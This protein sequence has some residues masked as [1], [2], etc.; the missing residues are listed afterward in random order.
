MT[1]RAKGGRLDYEAPM[2]ALTDE[3]R[4]KIAQ[5][6]PEILEFLQAGDKVTAADEPPIR[7][8][9]R[10][11]NLPL[12]FAQERLWFIDQLQPGSTGY[13]I[14]RALRILG[15]LQVEVLER[16]INEI[17]RR[18]EVLRTTF[19]TT[20]QGQPVQV[21]HEHEWRSVPMVDLEALSERERMEQARQLIEEERLRPF[22]LSRGPLMRVRLLQLG[23]TDQVISYT[24]HH[25][26]SDGWS[27]GVLNRELGVLYEAFANGQPS[28]LPELPIQYA[29]FAVW[30]REWLQ[31]E[32]L[33]KQL[34]Y[35]K[36]QLVGVIPLQLPTDYSRPVIQTFNGA[37][38]E[39]R[40][41]SETA[42]GLK[43]LCRDN[44]VTL[45]MTLLAGFQVLLSR[46]SGQEDIAVASPIANRHGTE[47]ENLIGFFVNM[48][49][50]RTDLSG[51]PTVL[52]LL[53]R[54][55]EVTLGAYSHQDLPFEKLVEELRPERDM[56]RNPLVQV[57]FALQNA[58]DEGLELRGIKLQLIGGAQEVTRLDLEAHFWESKQGITGRLIYNMDLFESG[59]IG[60]MAGHLERLLEEMV[61]KPEGRISELEL[62]G[63][64]EREQILVGWNQ[65]RREYPKKKCI[66]ELFEE[67]AK[68]S[69]EAVA[70]VFENKHLTYEELNR[71][72]NQLAHFLRGLG[73]KP[74]VPVGICVER[75]LDLI[76][77]LLGIWKAG[78]AY[79]PLD[80]AY[81]KERIT[82]ILENASIQILISQGP[83]AP[84][85]SRPGIQTVA[86]DEDWPLIVEGPIE[87]PDNGISVENLAYII[88]TSGFTGQPKGVMIEHR[89]LGHNAEAMSVPLSIDRNTRY[90]HTAS[91]GFFS[92]MRQFVLPLTRGGTLV[93]ASSEQI[94]DP[95]SLFRLIKGNHVTVIDLVPSYWRNCIFALTGLELESRTSLLDND[96]KLILSSGEALLSDLP[97]KWTCELKHGAQLVNMF[98]RA[99][100]TGIVSLFPI[101]MENGSAVRTVQ[102]GRPIANT[103]IYLLDKNLNPVPIGVAGELYI[104]GR[105]LAR[106]YSG[107]A[108]LTAE[109]F[110]GNPFSNEP[111]SRLYRTGDLCR[112]QPGGVM[113]FVGRIDAAR[114]K[115]FELEKEKRAIVISSTFTADPV[116]EPLKFWMSEL[117]ILAE[118]RL[119]PYNQVF[120]QLLDPAGLQARN[121]LGVS[122]VLIRIEDF[123]RHKLVETEEIRGQVLDFVA[124]V[125]AAADHSVCPYIVGLCP[126]S[127]DGQLGS[128][129]REM[130]DLVAAELN[131]SK[132]VRLIKSDEWKQAYPV[133]EY[134]D[135]YS[136]ELGHIPYTPE[137]YTAMGTVLARK[138]FAL[139]TLPYK[140]IAVD[141]DH[142]L[143]TGICAE[144]G[145]LGITIDPARQALQRF[146]LD[147]KEA[148]RLLCLCSKN[149]ESDVAEVFRTRS[150]MCLSR[151]DFVAWRINWKAKSENLK[152]LAEELGVGLDSFI[153]IDDNPLECAEVE[154]NCPQ[155]L[156][157]QL[158]QKSE[159]ISEFLEHLWVFDLLET[160]ETDKRRTQLY[161][162]NSERERFR[163]ESQSLEAFLAGLKLRLQITDVKF[164]QLPRV[165]QLTQRTNQFNTTAIRR[166]EIELERLLKGKEL[167][168]MVVEVQDRFGDYG[169][170]GAMLFKEEIEAISVDTFLLSCRV[171]GKG[172]EHRML[173][174]LGTIACQRGLEFVEVHYRATGKNQLA[175]DF[176][177]SAG[178]QS[179]EHQ[180]DGGVFRLTARS[181]KDLVYVPG[182]SKVGPPG[183]RANGLRTTAQRTSSGTWMRIALELSQVEQIRQ[184]LDARKQKTGVQRSR[185]YIAP[186]TPTEEILAGIWSSMLGVES[187][188]ITDDFFSLGGHSFLA[189]QFLSR[190]RSVFKVELPLK[191]LFEVPT[192][193]GLSERVEA[194]RRSGAGL[195]TPEIRRVGRDRSWPLSYAQEQLWQYC[196]WAL[197]QSDSVGLHV[198]IVLPIGGPLQ[199][200][201]LERAINEMV[202]RHEV[203]RT[204]YKNSEAGPVQVIHD[205]QYREL[206][207]ADLEGLK[208]QPREEELK[209]LITEDAQRLFDLERGPVLRTTLVRLG[210]D[211]HTILH[212]VHHIATDFFSQ[213]IW[214]RETR[215]LYDAFS[216]S[217]ESPLAE[218][219][220]QYADY[221]VW[222]RG[223]FQGEVAGKYMEYWRKQVAG[224][225]LLNLPTD[226]PRPEKSTPGA[227]VQEIRI[228]PALV[229]ELKKLND[230]GG[231]TSCM[232][233][234]AGVTVLINQYS[235]EEDISISL[236]IANRTQTET[237][238]L[239]GFFV[240]TLLFRT[241][242]QGDPT[243][244]ELLGKV[245]GIT[246]GAYTHQDVPWYI[247]V[248]ADLVK[249]LKDHYSGQKNI[250]FR[251]LKY[252]A[253]ESLKTITVRSLKTITRA[254][255]KP[256]TV[257]LL[258]IITRELLSKTNFRIAKA[259]ICGSMDDI[260][261]ESLVAGHS[262]EYLDACVRVM[263]FLIE[264]RPDLV[265]EILEDPKVKEW[266][267]L[268]AEFQI[269]YGQW[270]S[271]HGKY[272]RKVMKKVQPGRDMGRNRAHVVL[273]LAP[274]PDEE[275][276]LKRKISKQDRVVR[277]M[278]FDLMLDI[279]ENNLGLRISAA[280]NRDLFKPE[281]IA[282][283]LKDLKQV[284]EAFVRNPAKRISELDVGRHHEE[285]SP[286]VHDQN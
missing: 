148:G 42:K 208:E 237:E 188:G 232:A 16:T 257:R 24:L 136:D 50:M 106:G 219:P 112:Y 169:L 187:I 135:R 88:Y 174:S 170:T 223:C 85:V 151:V 211:R 60:Q 3:L 2:G 164:E 114:L 46:Y 218:L 102:I 202:R 72:A 214:K 8:Y 31:G 137:F 75:S 122:V 21:I 145:A 191:D 67:Q 5:R 12:S 203:L 17:V 252:I 120:Q 180:A 20:A 172:I 23:P 83:L 22:D 91:I 235:G 280:Y 140:V 254:L 86:L 221:A 84:V 149:D 44:D 146:L 246:L 61:K 33:E 70:V 74:E 285:N 27:M 87:N 11:R 261:L 56:S 185:E 124:A 68:R 228:R 207:V 35:W 179:R 153:F 229:K 262:G 51:D 53:E 272:V 7:R 62:M 249:S 213:E 263:V 142:T 139:F 162:Q 108:D 230:R 157:L 274:H 15:G 200:K 4:S 80:P 224:I 82:F 233:L 13:N 173:A 244:V 247:A 101:V 193:A 267:D 26:T 77:G 276:E 184:A 30:Q 125:R 216:E 96:L 264:L 76:V 118:V 190:V 182:K 107:R 166:T 177:K 152:S 79:V 192:V 250:K 253:R 14:L 186:R 143:W 268:V 90:L 95:Q 196:Y 65:T 282:R 255:L 156:T 181:L 103:Q 220:I 38:Q 133:K 215:L 167:E 251:L 284:L 130:E 121:E 238:K 154:A 48:L 286:R 128:V 73:V 198:P 210:V 69:P 234:L 49:V 277:A 205:H 115:A 126:G 131:G 278:S 64:E 271:L 81:P 175:L 159:A 43:G 28:P 201:A 245:K 71:N 97:E 25:I 240:N 34:N 258:K 93:I 266:V 283:I 55:K 10:D 39:L 40:I 225:R 176:L 18:H 138:V 9:P 281:T 99:E 165:A 98:G 242:L 134:Y 222:Q 212:T 110:I 199:V 116:E 105:G 275:V 37:V 29:D 89:E 100:T 256:A 6:K 127:P 32:A 183:P 123:Q 58:P 92:S 54:V 150:E 147:Q 158:P 111:G 57:L 241:D 194:L 59:T 155:V 41:S 273:N 78:G 204:T 104:G 94:Q 197:P 63:V 270:D 206:P 66:H 227:G 168:C 248:A 243:V 19:E 47:V 226:Y 117:D 113:E 236:V 119:T 45:F 163:A 265:R 189:I 279:A 129:G 209:R 36:E 160:T 171:F 52:E 217:R 239:I 259:I 132:A 161:Q 141:C 109:T 144:D 231:V 178:G 1:L 269:A 195:T 260:T